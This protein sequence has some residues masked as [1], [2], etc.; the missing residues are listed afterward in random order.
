MLI[1]EQPPASQKNPKQ[2][3]STEE[4]Q[5]P[6]SHRFAFDEVVGKTEESI[7]AFRVPNA[8]WTEGWRRDS[9]VFGLEE[10]ELE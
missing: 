2:T 1:F 10:E 9:P 8:T 7:P 6:F 4:Q 5:Q 3:S